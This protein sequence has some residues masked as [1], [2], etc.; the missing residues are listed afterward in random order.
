LDIAIELD[1]AAETKMAGTVYHGTY[2]NGIVLDNP[3]KQRPVTVTGKISAKTG[4]AIF[5]NNALAWTVDNF[6]TVD[7]TG[8]SGFGVQLNA[9]GVV[10]N[11]GA[12]ALVTGYGGIL[13]KGAA[14]V[15]DNLGTIAA[16]GKNVSSIDLSAGG[17]VVNGAAAATKARIAGGSHAVL[18]AG[19]AGTVV[20]FGAIE[21]T[22]TRANVELL[23]G[24]AVTNGSSTSTAARI[25]GAGT[26][27]YAA[28]GAGAVKN[29]GTIK[30]SNGI[31]LLDGGSVSNGASGS[32]AGLIAATSGNAVAIAGAAGAVANFGTITAA[33]T[34]PTVI[35]EAGGMVVNGAAGAAAA[36]VS[37]SG[38][39]VYVANGRGTVTNFGT[40]DAASTSQGSGV[41]LRGGGNLA[42]FG[43]IEST[44]GT[45]SGVY[46]SGTGVVVNGAKTSLAATIDGGGNGVAVRGA[47][48]SLTN[49]G[50]IAGAANDGVYL[51]LG[52]S[53]LN[54]ASGKI[55]GPAAGIAARNGAAMV[56]NYGRIT[57]V[58]A[59]AKG[60]ALFAGGTVTNGKGGSKAGLIS[61]TEV[62]VY[63]KNGTANVTNFGTI[64]G[65]T[66]FLAAGAGNATLTN[67]GTVASIQGAAGVAVDMAG[68]TGNGLLIVERGAVFVGRVEGGGRGEIEFVAAGAANLANV[69][70]F[71]TIALANGVGHSLTLSDANFA[72]V[73]GGTIT[74][75][76][77]NRGNTIDGSRLTSAG[78]T[79]VIEAGAGTDILKGGLG[80]DIFVFAAADLLRTDKV[81]GG[82]G[83]NELLL[84]TAGIIAAGGVSG[85]ETYRL[86]AGG[87]NSLVLTNA[88]FAG[89]N[90]STITVHC[91][92]HGNTIDG[93]AVS[94]AAN[95][96]VIDGG[97]G[98]DVLKGGAGND[99][100]VFSARALTN[101]D[102][103]SGGAGNN[104]LLMTSAGKI[105]AAGVTGVETWVLA[106]GGANT[107]NLTKVNFTGTKGSITIADGNGS[108]TVSAATLPAT[109]RIVVY[110]GSGVDKLVG[111]AGGDIFYAGGRTT[112]TGKTGTN[113]FIFSA[114]GHNVIT[115][116]S[117]SITNEIVVS[118]SG[119]NLKL[120]GA[121]SKPTLLPSGLFVA[122]ATGAF[123]KSSQRFAYDTS[124]GELFFSA[125]G[126]TK[127]EQ[128]VVTLTG[129]PSLAAGQV[130]FVA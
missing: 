119:F 124:D 98:A 20:N 109:D 83:N 17:S 72:G 28:N 36:L 51:Q 120:S 125:T 25:D 66:G 49:F 47:T 60:V 75:F 84:T 44:N 91:G 45:T 80:N 123:T 3:A 68:G 87:R 39:G 19:A 111:G 65:A 6:G 130:F 12:G 128:L 103:I 90:G 78:E 116:F 69:S 42:N 37:G 92:N 15:V 21:N 127:N 43:K 81:T 11:A 79:L 129:H 35:L 58:G 85:V 89:I 59:K 52:G 106:D 102:R 74:V 117:A 70:G 14:G 4:D 7:A 115:D 26:A 31:L 38:S 126:S 53:V 99:I 40:I 82:G 63:V 108:N 71:A 105:A 32:A 97:S 100:F 86:A 121:G 95:S 104:E 9:G 107:L 122:N 64:Q 23:A 50:A 41:V 57:A 1:V 27:I 76:G 77:G 113:E 8:T 24:G 73:A 110:A 56:A 46:L 5:G 96:L 16:T 33:G 114:P 67:F 22:G 54:Q 34:T 2:L 112:M 118:N 13:F 18:I 61:G 55:S 48:A 29:F 88:N 101:T 93:S 94:L 30:G 62:G 10:D